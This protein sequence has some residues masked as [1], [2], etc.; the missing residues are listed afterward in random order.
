[1]FINVCIAYLFKS[2][3]KTGQVHRH[4]YTTLEVWHWLI[5]QYRSAM[6]F[7]IGIM[8][9][10]WCTFYSIYWESRA[11]VFRALLAHSQE[12]LHKR[13]LVYCVLIMS[14]VARLQWI[15]FNL[16]RIKGFYMFRVLLAHPQ[17][18]LHKTAFGILRACNVGWLWYVCSEFNS[19]YWVW[20]ACVCFDHYLLI[21][22]KRCK[23]GIWY[24]S[25]YV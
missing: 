24:I 1:M 8:K 7:N 10:M 17:E 23:N 20:R 12:M 5:L 14:V 16:L 9:P 19:F 21:F 3:C 25:R 2:L 15:S 4:A 18:V 6:S 11:S 22:R 13:H